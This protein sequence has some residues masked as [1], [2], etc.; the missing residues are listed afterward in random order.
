MPRVTVKDKAVIMPRQAPIET[1]EYKKLREAFVSD[2]YGGSIWE[3][4]QITLVAPVSIF[5][6]TKTLV[7]ADGKCHD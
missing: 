1:E 7:D 6:N 2:H 4:N 3:I 5:V